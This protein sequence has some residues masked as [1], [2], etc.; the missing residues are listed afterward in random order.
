[1][2]RMFKK[3]F[4]Y[5]M[6]FATCAIYIWFILILEKHFLI[7]IGMRLQTARSVLNKICIYQNHH[8]MQ[9]FKT[10]TYLYMQ[11][12]HFRCTF[13]ILNLLENRCISYGL[14]I[15]QIQHEKD[16]RTYI[17]YIEL[18]DI[19]LSVLNHL[20]KNIQHCFNTK[21]KTFRC[22]KCISMYYVIKV[23]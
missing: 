19:Y 10:T 17:D 13:L 15:F 12:Q 5:V 7:K 9:T 3:I 14:P 8:A 16:H 22:G 20:K 6:H 2:H 1:M 21:F 23:Y 4:L 11:Y 18:F